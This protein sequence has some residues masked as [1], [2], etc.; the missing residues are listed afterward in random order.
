M[1]KGTTGSHQRVAPEDLLAVP[2]PDPRCL[3]VSATETI[4]AAVRLAGAVKRE[5]ACLA[6]VRDALLPKVLSGE[7]RVRDAEGYA[8]NPA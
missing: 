1:V 7:V 2:I 8:R 6:A 5:S 4:A 3:T